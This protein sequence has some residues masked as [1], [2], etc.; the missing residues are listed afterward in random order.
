[1][2]RLAAG[3]RGSPVASSVRPPPPSWPRSTP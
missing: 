1:V 2:P 3:P